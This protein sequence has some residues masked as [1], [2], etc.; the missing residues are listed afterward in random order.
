MPA[1]AERLLQST[2]Q[3]IDT[4]LDLSRPAASVA[5]FKIAELIAKIRPWIDYGLAVGMGTL[6]NEKPKNEDGEDAENDTDD[7]DEEESS[8][9]SP[10]AFQVGFF[11]PQVYQFFDV[12]SALR[13]VTMITY[14]EDGV[15]VTHSETHIEDLKKD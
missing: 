1:T 14:E 15:W 3:K 12:L 2:P 6:K 13:S 7:A 8:Q 10:L 5:H 4:S 11:M 9:P